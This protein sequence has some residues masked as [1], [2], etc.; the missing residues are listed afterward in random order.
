MIT[1]KADYSV[2]GGRVSRTITLPD[3]RARRT[4]LKT[5]PFAESAGGGVFAFN[6]M[7]RRGEASE[8]RFA[9]GEPEGCASIRENRE[10]RRRGEGGLKREQ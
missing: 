6:E 1:V 4:T 8:G 9:V 2:K 5:P 10:K 3:G 7:R